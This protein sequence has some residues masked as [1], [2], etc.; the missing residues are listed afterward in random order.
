MPFTG[1]AAQ[2]EQNVSGGQDVYY[3]EGDINLTKTAPADSSGSWAG[4]GV[5][6][7]PFGDL[8][9]RLRGRDELIDQL[10]QLLLDPDDRAHALVG[11]GGTGKSAIAL[12]V[13]AIAREQGMSVWWVEAASIATSMMR[14]SRMLGADHEAFAAVQRGED[15]PTDLLWNRL[16]QRDKWLVVINNADDIATLAVDGNAVSHGNGWIRGSKSGLL[17]LTTRDSNE[18]SWGHGVEFHYVNWLDD[19]SGSEI[20]C[21]LAP[22]AGT[23]A[24]AAE[25]SSRLGGLPLALYQAGSYIRSSPDPETGTFTGYK[26]ALETQFPELMESSD[27]LDDRVLVTRTWELS[28]DQLAKRGYPGARRLLEVLS[29]FAGG[30]PIPTDRLNL[31]A[32]SAAHCNEGVTALRRA[33]QQLRNVGLLEIRQASKSAPYARYWVLHPL[34]AETTRHRLRDQPTHHTSL[35][36]AVRL[37]VTTVAG[38]DPAAQA[39]WPTWQDWLPH[40]SGMA[41]STQFVIDDVQ[42]AELKSVLDKIARATSLA[43]PSP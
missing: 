40:A 19:G 16:E 43:V 2:S 7:P 31:K 28:L 32:L 11:L 23:L 34:V 9:R 26:E 8:P 13:A 24:E 27:D 3:A 37:L 14:L 29:W 42:L 25:L 4:K 10:Q 18:L 38:L 36:A 22:D 21:D 33:A 6:A 5:L 12:K 1:K 35:A 39:D 30:T 17:L 15:D 41:T 20:L